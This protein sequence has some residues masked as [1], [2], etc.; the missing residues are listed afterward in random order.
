MMAIFS[1][2]V[3]RKIEVFMDDFS[4]VEVSFYDCL[5]NLRA[6]LMR[7]EETNLELN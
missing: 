7:C 2:M 1:D 3:E 4:V 6:V 5:E